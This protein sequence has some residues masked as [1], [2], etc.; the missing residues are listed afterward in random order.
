[1]SQPLRRQPLVEQTAAHLREGFV[2]GRW[3]GYLPGVLQLAG[4]LMVSK[5]LVR[6]ALRILEEEGSIEDCGAGKRRKILMDRSTGTGHRHLRIAVMLHDSLEQEDALICRMLLDIRE[7]IESSGHTCVFAPESLA[8]TGDNL[9]RISRLVKQTKADGWILF[10]ASA[11]VIEWFVTQPFATFAL[12]GRYAGLPVASSAS[13]TWPAIR[14]AVDLL[15]GLGHRRIVW[16][17]PSFFRK[18]V[19]GPTGQKFMNHLEELGIPAS[20]YNMPDYEDTGEG[21]AKLMDQLFRITPPTALMFLDPGECLAALLHLTRLGLRVPQDVSIL[22]M[23]QEPSMRHLRPRI[24]QFAL[25]E[26]EHV[27]R[28]LRWVQCIAKRKPDLRQ[29]VFEA[30]FSAGESIGPAKR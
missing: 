29:I 2:S 12:G 8:Q 20:G 18:P 19:L 30:R 10:Q 21:L 25:P 9:A 4:E 11:M 23:T 7:T 22:C 28:I 24:T 14:S 16:V 17:W 6:G 3:T 26:K 15:A 5:H 1:M 27:R 13:D